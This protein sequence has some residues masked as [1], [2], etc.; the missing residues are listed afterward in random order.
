MAEIKRIQLRGISRAPSD[1][2][3][4][5]GGVAESLNVQIDN[6]EAAPIV[7][8]K[9]V[10]EKWEFPNN[11]KVDYAYIHKTANFERLIIVADHQIGY[12]RDGEVVNFLALELS[13]SVSDITSMGNTLVISTTGKMLYVLWKDGE[14]I[15]LGSQVPFP[16]I[17]LTSV[18]ED[19]SYDTL[20]WSYT[21]G[22]G[23]EY[24][25]SD[26]IPAASEWDAD[27]ADGKTHTNA[28]ILRLLRYINAEI[29]RV[30]SDSTNK[31]LFFQRIFVRYTATLYDGSKLSSIP[32]LLGAIG[33]HDISLEV[34]TKVYDVTGALISANTEAEVEVKGA[35]KIKA[36]LT[37]LEELQRWTDVIQYIDF[38]ASSGT[39]L[40]FNR[41]SSSITPPSVVTEQGSTGTGTTTETTSSCKIKFNVKDDTADRLL[42]DSALTYLVKRISVHPAD[43][44]SALTEEMQSLVNGITI[45]KPEVAEGETQEVLTEDDMKHYFS[46]AQRHITY[47]NSLLLLQPES[48]L[49][50]TYEWLN[51]EIESEPT[52][53]FVTTTNYEAIFLLKG[54]NGEDKIAR[55]SFTS[56][57]FNA[58]WYASNKY[59]FQVFPDSRCYKLIVKATRTQRIGYFVSMAQTKY[60]ELEMLP[61]PYLDCAYHYAGYNKTLWELCTLDEMPE[62][63]QGLSSVDDRQNYLFMSEMNNPFFFPTERKYAFSS[64][65]IGAAVAT[66]AL[67]Q[68][69]FGQFPLYVFT[70]DG[71]YAMQVAD[72]GSIMTSKPLSRDVCINPA[73]IVS[74]DQAV[75]FLAQDG[76]KLLRG[77]DVV[78]ISPYMLRQAQPVGANQTTIIGATE[79]SDLLPAITEAEQFMSFMKKAKP[80]YDYAG[81]RIIFFS[82]EE[83]GYQYIYSFNTQTW[84][85]STYESKDIP[86]PLNSYPELLVLTQ[87]TKMQ[88]SISYANAPL[89]GWRDDPGTINLHYDI[90]VAFN[91]QFNHAGYGYLRMTP[92]QALD[93]IEGRYSIPTTH[94]GWSSKQQA[95]VNFFASTFGLACTI[96]RFYPMTIQDYSTTYDGTEDLQ[97]LKSVII[98]RPLDLGYPDVRKKISDLRVRGQ[99]P[100]GAVKF[101]LE[102]SDDGYTFYT[103]SSLRGKSW[104]L[105][106]LTLLCDL[107]PDDR[108]SWV[109]V[110]FETR[111]TNKLR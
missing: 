68:G 8:P 91:R 34:F 37:N 21:A 100:K 47:N 75:V 102:G 105:F 3:T 61:H 54:D 108:V 73:S 95:I 90:A 107:G 67:S 104:K 24:F 35:F 39:P 84:H 30:M 6:T 70:E 110:Q 23:G 62:V 45:G 17:K 56:A 32:V 60:A 13:E 19:V 15:S 76:V 9:D 77:S 10:S 82:S 50:Y 81:K 52:S 4:E 22:Q 94:L 36:V 44:S 33:Q 79:F 66:F 74:I 40:P 86:I 88:Y 25:W 103:L 85:K 98:T 7:Q 29:D 65:V 59:S 1:R 83:K 20:T 72:D 28:A 48:I 111:F 89:T 27:S 53:T 31:S 57:D 58:S 99:F 63:P 87:G 5:D 43:G 109:D 12:V 16:Q 11:L 38:Y 49:A 97:T 64:A 78:N 92:Q 96:N 93:F 46:S 80:E 51:N 26:H 55:K 18:Y 2:L 106:R 14:Y 71:I 41:L 69:Q 101:I 42:Q